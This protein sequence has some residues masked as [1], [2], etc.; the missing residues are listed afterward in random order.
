M[1]VPSRCHVN[2]S[3]LR[4]RSWE[5]ITLGKVNSLFLYLINVNIIGQLLVASGLYTSISKY[6]E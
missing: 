3:N 2:P 5:K 4:V 6:T 1:D